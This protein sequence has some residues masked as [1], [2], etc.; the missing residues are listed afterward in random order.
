MQKN[1]QALSIPYICL[2]QGKCN[3]LFQ[4][5]KLAYSGGHK[6]NVISLSYVQNTHYTFQRPET[7]SYSLSS[8][9]SMY[10]NQIIYKISYFEQK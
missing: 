7:R 9:N 1:D 5:R 6:Q 4:F 2:G 3:G 10:T 8:P